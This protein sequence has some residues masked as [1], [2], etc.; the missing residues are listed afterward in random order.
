MSRIARAFLESVFVLL[1]CFVVLVMVVL[2][3]GGSP[4]ALRLAGAVAAVYFVARSLYRPASPG[5]A[6]TGG[7]GA[8]VAGSAALAS[9]AEDDDG[10][11]IHDASWSAFARDD[12]HKPVSFDINP[13]NGLPMMGAVDVMGNAYGT[14]SSTA[15]DSFGSSH[16]GFG[17]NG[18][19]SF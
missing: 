6:V 1:A 18:N 9:L 13:A 15:F 3:K 4:T 14:D 12:V 10:S 2:D 11:T 7:V 17:G 5:R 8:G 19:S 16:D